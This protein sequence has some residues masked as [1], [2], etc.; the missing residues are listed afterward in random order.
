MPGKRVSSIAVVLAEPQAVV[1]TLGLQGEAVVA[2]AGP[3]PSPVLHEHQQLVLAAAG[4]LVYRFQ[5]QPVLT[6]R[7]PEAH[8]CM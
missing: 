6:I 4:E 1:V 8:L 2:G 5:A 7:P 3:T